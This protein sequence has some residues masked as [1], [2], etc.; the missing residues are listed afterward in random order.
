MANTV[1]DKNLG[2]S[3]N[4]QLTLDYD[5]YKYGWGK[6]LDKNNRNPEKQID[7]SGWVGFL[8]NS[9]MNNV[10]KYLG[11]EVF[12]R[13][14][15]TSQDF[16]GAAEIIRKIES[17]TGFLLKG[18]DIT[19]DSLREGMIIGEDNGP[20]IDRRTGK[21][22]D[23]GRYKGIDHIVAVVKNPNTGE[24]MISQSASSKGG[25]S[26]IT[27]D[28]YFEEIGRRRHTK[29][30]LA[31]PLHNI[32]DEL[33]MKQ[34]ELEQSSESK[35]SAEAA[36]REAA[37]ETFSS[38]RSLAKHMSDMARKLNPEGNDNDS[39]PKPG[40]SDPGMDM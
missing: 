19:K 26:L 35:P 40:G 30:F 6:R 34:R 23:A 24:L 29:L 8:V 31:D 39:S 21:I 33:E 2:F 17:R 27:V 10:N 25:V 36:N 16:D 4:Y 7:C 18:S 9:D 28:Q 32:R 15:Y 3:S 22:R 12:K 5:H 11:R 38:Q 14:E 13:N 20:S 37:M 1:K